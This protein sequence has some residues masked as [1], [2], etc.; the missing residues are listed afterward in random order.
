MERLFKIVVLTSLFSFSVSPFFAETIHIVK[1]GETLY[2]ISRSYGVSVEAIQNANGF[3][4]NNVRVEQKITIPDS[5]S[6][7]IDSKTSEKADTHVV[8]KGETLY[9]ISRIYNISVDELKSLNNL[10][11]NN[12][13]IGQ[14]LIISK[15]VPKAVTVDSKEL[16]KTSDIEKTSVSSKNPDI[17]YT[18]QK[19]DTWLGI[20]ITYGLTL[21]EIQK[22][23][24]V[25][26][27]DIIKVGQRVKVSKIPDLKDNDPHVY[28]S[29]KGDA[30]LVWP[31][32]TSDVTY[33]TGK[34]N[35][36]SLTAKK[37]E[38]VKSITSGN[39]V[40]AG[41]YRG[42]GNVVFVQNKTGHIYAYTGLSN[43]H[44]SKGDY[45]DF[46]SDVG[47]VGIDAYTQNPQVN[48]MVFQKSTPIDPAKAP[49]G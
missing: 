38:T 4:N 14:E 15:N 8:N 6:K 36:V 25:T 18:V 12:V 44:V 11:N 1:K 32:K 34:V 30:S 35:G 46:G 43:V 29:K 9:S 33:V 17:Y 20:A 42:Y 7:K 16:K 2:S 5:P 39:V 13:K 41:T 37:N 22:I 40:V 26:D 10:S 47:T 21:S 23:N 49:R 31:V 19:G 3:A 48:L 28:S 27:A 45:V 24:N